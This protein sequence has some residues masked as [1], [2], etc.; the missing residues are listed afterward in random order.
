MPRYLFFSFTL[1]ML[2]S[3]A[4]VFGE[5]RPERLNGLIVGK[6][7]T[8]Y[9][10]T[11]KKVQLSIQPT[12]GIGHV[13]KTIYRK[14]GGQ[15]DDQSYLNTYDVRQEITYVDGLGR[16]LQVVNP[17][18]SPTLKDVVQPIEYDGFGRQPRRYLSYSNGD[19]GSYKS[20]A[21]TTGQGLYAFYNNTGQH[22]LSTNHPYA[23]VEFDKSP[24]NRIVQ[25]GGIGESWQPYN[26]SIPG[27]GHTLKTITLSNVADEVKLWEINGGNISALLYF[28][29][30]KLNKTVTKDANWTSGKA[31]TTELFTDL[32]GKVVLKRV[33][34]TEIASLSTYYVYSMSGEL[35][36]IV[37]PSVNS[38][39]ITIGDSIFNEHLYAYKY[40][41]RG[42][43]IEKKIPGVGWGFVVY[44]EVNLPVLVQDSVQ[45]EANEWNYVKY[46]AQGRI[47]LTG[48]YVNGSSRSVVQALVNSNTDLWESRLNTSGSGYTS[49]AFP[50]GDG[51]EVY[52]INFYDDYNL[53]ID[54]PWLTVPQGC[55][56]LAIGVP[57][58]SKTKIL[59]SGNYLWSVNYYDERGRLTASNIQNLLGGYDNSHLVFTDD[60]IL[61]SSKRTHVNNTADTV[62][63][64]ER[65]DYDHAGRITKA[66]QKINNQP[67]VVLAAYEY[68]ELGEVIRKSLHSIDDGNS[69]LQALTYQ[70]NIQG[71]LKSINDVDISST[72]N[73]KFGMELSYEDAPI[74]EYGG[75]VGQSKWK[76]ARSPVSPQLGYDYQY[77]K[78][79]RL[80]AAES[81]TNGFKD[82][83]YSEYASY[84]PMGNIQTIGRY[85]LIEGTGREQIDSLQYS[86]NGNRHIRI[87]DVSNN[88]SAAIKELGFNDRIQAADEY[89]YDGNGRLV[90]DLNMSISSISYNA[91]NLPKEI[92]W[93]GGTVK[94]MEN[95]YTASGSKLRKKFTDGSTVF[96]TDYI[97]GLQYTTV[98]TGPP[99]LEFIMTSEGRARYNGTSFVYEY[100]LKDNLGNVRATIDAEPS[101]VTQLT[102][103]VI[104]ENSYYPFGMVMPN[105]NINFAAG[106]KNNY[107]YNGKELQE[108]LGQLDYGARFYDPA[109]A[110]WSVSDP[111]A[112]SHY[113]QSAYNYVLNNPI[114]FI[115]PF[116]LKEYDPNELIGDGWK[117]FNPRKDNIGLNEVKITNYDK[118]LDENW[119]ER[120]G[121]R[122][123]DLKDFLGIFNRYLESSDG[124]DY[125]DIANS[126]SEKAYRA[127]W[128][129][130]NLKLINSVNSGIGAF[131][132]G[133]G[134]KTEILDFAI[135]S[136]FKSAKGWGEFKNLR[137]GQQ[138]WRTTNALGKTGA[139]YLKGAKALGK[140]VFAVTVLTSALNAGSAYMNDDPNVVGV[141]GK[142]TLDIAMGYVGFLGPIGF[143]ISATYFILDASGA[144]DSWGQPTYK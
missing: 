45:R 136:K 78:L 138:S 109:I 111:L 3:G 18:A 134:A 122:D 121:N 84:D 13:I 8:M 80:S 66:M 47:V 67:E 98:G 83:N 137:P 43:V 36:F 23:E 37:P 44:N 110:R 28:P 73:T 129:K 64:R 106:V 128:D 65:F 30:G 90:S 16:A 75:N 68:N 115:D 24:L 141:I 114:M 120:T 85:A 74:P 99:Q 46:D 102:A 40:D 82:K 108:E 21:L 140:G 103:R 10:D 53:P 9:S 124:E 87:D 119:A 71:Q 123:A 17:K 50:A 57:T 32:Q 41:D 48:R 101:D 94:K 132:F 139:S 81:L 26:S 52:T 56:S 91:A 142:A 104:Q 61:V 100:D 11:A 5:N 58:A 72:G 4:H 35:R 59:N 1:W 14:K 118:M 49:I 34:E 29:A 19:D 97:S 6:G 76:V 39:N 117:R 63:I 70:Y 143:G 22:R 79:S 126:A 107:L 31:G 60:G 2:F 69:F 93:S 127:Q 92:I 130:D 131:G 96:T 27:S 25:Q 62:V 86:Y 15:I 116:G 42:R 33:H 20:D 112:E 12:T 55:M 54:C 125:V 89:L 105:P 95:T 7:R 38:N 113:D 51:S 144:F 133:N 88:S 77:D 135:R